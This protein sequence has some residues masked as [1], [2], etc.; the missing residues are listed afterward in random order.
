MLTEKQALD[1]RSRHDA[2]RAWLKAQKRNSYKTEELRAA[3]IKEP[4]NDETS[5]LEVF[6]FV[7]DKPEKYFAYVRE[8]NAGTYGRSSFDRARALYAGTGA[9][10]TWTG[11][12]LG[13]MQF[14][15]AFRDNFGGIRVPVSVKAINGSVYHGTYFFSA[16][17]YCRLKKAK[18]T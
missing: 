5:A 13:T 10:Q 8:P 4:T 17:D 6:E 1:I 11:E 18:A 16:G 12:N 2:A 14:G 7:R 9:L 3:G 15:A